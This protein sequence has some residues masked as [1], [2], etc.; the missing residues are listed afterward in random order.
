[1]LVF[2]PVGSGHVIGTRKPCRL[3]KQRYFSDRCRQFNSISSHVSPLRRAVLPHA[4]YARRRLLGGIHK[5]PQEIRL[6]A[7]ETAN[8]S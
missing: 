4:T 8:A 5:V 2:I 6:A 7:V 1:M 3:H